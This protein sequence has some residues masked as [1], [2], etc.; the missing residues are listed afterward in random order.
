MSINSALL[1]GTAGLS[2]NSTA[3]AAISDNIANVNTVGYKR[4]QS[5]FVPLVKADSNAITYNAG[6]VQPRNRQ[7]IDEQGL[8]QSSSSST[9]L[10]ISGDGFFVVTT[11]SDPLTSSDAILFTRSGSFAPD[12]RGF[13]TNSAGYFLQGWPV[14]ADGSV[15][16]NASDVSALEVVNISSIGGTAEATTRARL[17][18]NVQASTPI[19][20][21]AA[22]Y[23]AAVPANNMAS[24]AVQPDFETSI[25]IFDTQGGIRTVTVM[26]L[27][28]TVPNEWH[29]ELVIEPA[30]DVQTGAG[31]NNGQIATGIMAFDLLGRLDTANT[32]LPATLDF[33]ASDF[34]GALGANQFKWAAATGVGAQSVNFDIGQGLAAGGF[35]QFDSESILDS[36]T[37]NGS[38]FGDLSGIDVDKNGFV[39]AKFTNGVIKSI[40]QLPVATFINPN[41]LQPEN[42]GAFRVSPNSGSFNLKPAG[43]GGA[44]LVSART[45]ESS[46]VDLATEFTNLIMTQRAYSASSKIVTT[47]DEMLDELIRMKR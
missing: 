25:Q 23:N 13:L 41:G 43:A 19:S 9:D 28:S 38:I 21:A 6:G 18:A 47:A 7:L 17:N 39:I 31:L 24:G 12:D 44:G 4:T 46:N 16:T 27:K 32:T 5:L 11:H 10:G 30:T 1:A 26:M 22:T 14:A 35:T 40:Y 37:V 15:T 34:A 45:L 33:L 29:T 3:L 20:V 36:T 2:S 8:L 42:G